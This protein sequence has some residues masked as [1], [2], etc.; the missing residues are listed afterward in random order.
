MRSLLALSLGCALGALLSLVSPH[1][2]ESRTSQQ[3]HP[4]IHAY[5]D[6]NNMRVPSTRLVLKPNH[7]SRRFKSV[8]FMLEPRSPGDDRLYFQINGQRAH[9]G[10]LFV[11]TFRRPGKYV[12]RVLDDQGRPMTLPAQRLLKTV[13]TVT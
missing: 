11:V 4:P 12:A 7:M 10:S 8:T 6:I 3:I 9:F 2:A 1:G 5:I 13:F